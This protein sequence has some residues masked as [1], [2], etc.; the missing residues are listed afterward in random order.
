[1]FAIPNSLKIFGKRSTWKA[2]K[3]LLYWFNVHNYL[4]ISVRVFVCV[5]EYVI[6]QQVEII[7]LFV[8]VHGAQC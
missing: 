1:L 3:V 6:K 7:V 4:K 5:C 2:L 8:T